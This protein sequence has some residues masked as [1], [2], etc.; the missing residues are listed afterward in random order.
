M[1]GFLVLFYFTGTPYHT[2]VKTLV[3]INF[4]IF[5]TSGDVEVKRKSINH[6]AKAEGLSI[7]KGSSNDDYHTPYFLSFFL[8]FLKFF[9]FQRQG[10]GGRKKGR[11]TLM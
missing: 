1:D 2:P 10:K 6:T 4:F 9:F 8:S 3:S 5:Q 11:Q 7:P